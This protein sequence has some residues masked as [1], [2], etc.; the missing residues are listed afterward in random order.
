MVMV[1]AAVGVA[2]VNAV[3][4]PHTIT[5]LVPV[6]GAV[7]D[8]LVVTAVAVVAVPVV[9]AVAVVVPA[10]AVPVLLVWAATGACRENCGI[11]ARASATTT[12]R[13]S[14]IDR[15]ESGLDILSLLVILG[16][17]ACAERHR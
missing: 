5:E 2:A 7:V 3:I 8:V 9:T 6:D 12:K 1:P 14:E 17:P 4:G 10:V 13:Q 16:D 15:L 11:T